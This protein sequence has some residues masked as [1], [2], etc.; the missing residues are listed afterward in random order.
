MVL[1]KVMMKVE[2]SWTPGTMASPELIAECSNL[3]SSNYGLWSGRSQ[4]HAGQ[5]IRLS[6]KRISKWFVSD[7]AMVAQARLGGV[8]IGYAIAVRTRVPKYGIV[9]WVTQ[10]VV[11]EKYRK[12]DIGK[13]LLFSIWGLSDHFAWGVISSNPYAIRALEKATRRRC[14]PERIMKNR[15]KLVSLGA[16]HVPYV[17]ARAEVEITGDRSKINT[18]FYVDHSGLRETIARV[19]TKETPW[20]LGPIE[21][22][23]EW[24]AFTF[25]DQGQIALTSEEVM[26]M[27]DVSDQVTR[28]AYS[29]M[30]LGVSHRWAH[31][32]DKEAALIRSY[33]SLQTGQAVLDFGCGPGRHSFALATMG[34]NVVGVDYI[35]DFIDSA[36]DGAGQLQGSSPTFIVGDCRNVVLGRQFDA[37]ICL[38]DVIGTYAENSENLRILENIATHLKPDG[39]ALI[40][41]M[42]YELTEHLAK[43]TFSL[44]NEPNRLL[45]FPASGT[46]ERTGDVFNPEYYMLDKAS[47]V[48]YR[49]EQFVEGNLLPTELI[50]R[51]RRFRKQEIEEMCGLAGLEVVWSR[52]VQAGRW[53]VPLDSR[54]GK[55]KE[56]LLLCRK[57]RAVAKNE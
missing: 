5:R 29:R 10:L 52:F 28:L 43:H 3:Y 33:C 34:L 55:A 49:K 47:Q 14:V 41:V 37:A 40:S 57:R 12:Q 15:R 20:L 13:T 1:R 6:P 50:V 39:R 11:E 26:K 8:L 44:R 42:N 18:E 23:W 22:G 32:T 9:S 46:M 17:S 38:C 7:D 21:E 31:H 36:S 45:M 16:R 35:E 54:N 27:I 2:Y 30:R 4:E 48:V 51:D 24:F 53:D 56:I 25:Q 19:T